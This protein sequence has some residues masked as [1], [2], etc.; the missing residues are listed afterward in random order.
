MFKIISQL[1]FIGL[2]VSLSIVQIPA[3]ATTTSLDDQRKVEV[4][5]YKWFGESPQAKLVRVINPYGSVSSRTAS[6]S[7]VELSGAIQRIGDAPPQH[8]IEVKEQRGVIEV[9]V[10]YPP[11]SIRDAAGRLTGRVDLGV[12]IPSWVSLSVET[13]YGDIKVKKSASNITARSNSGKISIGTSGQVDAISDSGDIQLDLYAEKYRDS[14]R[15]YS[16]SGDIR[17]LVSQG[18]QLNLLAVAPQEIKHNFVDY[19]LIDVEKSTGSLQVRLGQGSLTRAGKAQINPVS[20]DLRTE[21]GDMSIRVMDQ[22]SYQIA[23]TPVKVLSVNNTP[24]ATQLSQGKR[25]EK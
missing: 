19:Q 9:I 21:H 3:S 10:S 12:W 14:M 17:V 13:D 18:A 4:E 1:C 11:D 15:V 2:I 16:R 25:S 23:K 20:M 22:P 24:Q 8:H 7:K 5:L 6:V